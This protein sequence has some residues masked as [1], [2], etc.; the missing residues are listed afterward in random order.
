MAPDG[1]VKAGT[2]VKL[3]EMLTSEEYLGCCCFLDNISIIYANAC[4]S[5]DTEYMVAFLLTYR[6]FTTPSELMELVCNRFSVSP[7]ADWPP[8]K[9]GIFDWL[10]EI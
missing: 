9:Q 4:I 3:V 1:S 7:P 10:L 2:V 5:S 8:E 6:S